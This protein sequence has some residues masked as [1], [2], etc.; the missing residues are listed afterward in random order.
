[1]TPGDQ[2]TQAP[3]VA[4]VPTT[5]ID[6]I[7][8]PWTRTGPGQADVVHSDGL[9]LSFGDKRILSDIHIP[10]RRGTITALIGPT[11]GGKSHQPPTE[12]ANGPVLGALL[13]CH[14]QL[15]S[16]G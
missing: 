1:M 3:F 14:K 16:A 5:E 4:G 10:F 9:S 8:E 2:F 7:L 15:S 12:G 6:P 11:G 13:A